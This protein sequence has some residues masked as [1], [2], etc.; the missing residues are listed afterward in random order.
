MRDLKLE[1]VVVLE[2]EETNDKSVR[3]R[4]NSA[5][6]EAARNLSIP[7][8]IVLVVNDEDDTAKAHAAMDDCLGHYHKSV[9][10]WAMLALFVLAI[11]GF[12]TV[13]LFLR[14]QHNR[15]YGKYFFD[16]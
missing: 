14:G 12:V 4:A 10:A 8:D 15:A 9:F 6:E 13:V 1:E 16:R 11:A 7:R 2:G 3:S 5:T